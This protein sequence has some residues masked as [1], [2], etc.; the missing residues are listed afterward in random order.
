MR[1]ASTAPAPDQT[2]IGGKQGRAET[3]GI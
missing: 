1:F 2:Q 3:E